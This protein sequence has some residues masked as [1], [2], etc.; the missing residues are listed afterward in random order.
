MGFLACWSHVSAFA[1]IQ[2][3]ASLCKQGHLTELPLG[4]N[5]LTQDALVPVFLDGVDRDLGGVWHRTP[6]PTSDG[7]F[8]P[9]LT[10]THRAPFPQG[11]AL[12]IPDTFPVQL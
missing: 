11:Q 12:L 1:A 8:Y 3:L 9:I 10:S 5:P 4:L 6:E 2:R 7:H